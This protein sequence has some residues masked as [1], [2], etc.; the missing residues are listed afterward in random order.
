MAPQ[1]LALP[2]TRPT[3]LKED[4][5]QQKSSAQYAHYLLR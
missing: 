1:E 5:G 2:G 4:C 3:D